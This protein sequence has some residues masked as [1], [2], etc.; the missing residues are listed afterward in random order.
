MTGVEFN[1][2]LDLVIDRP[3]SRYWSPPQRNDFIRMAITNAI[4]NRTLRND[5]IITEDAL[6][7]IY[8]SNATFTPTTNTLSLVAGGAGI[9]DYFH[10]MNLRAKYVIPV[11]VA[12]GVS[13]YIT[14]AS[15]STPLRIKL[16]VNTNLRTDSS[17]LISGVTTNTNANGTRYLKQISPK[18][19]ELYSDASLSTPIVGNG[20][21]TGTSGTIQMILNNYAKP[22]DSNHKFSKLGEATVDNPL[23]EISDTVVKI[24]PLTRVC[25]EATID[26]V[27]TPVYINVQD[28]VIDLNAT[29]GEDFLNFI[30]QETAVL[31]GMAS[32]DNEMTGN[33]ITVINQ[34]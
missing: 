11:S 15:N 16:N 10:L 13:V 32:R 9:S 4:N 22:L 12:L 29:Y 27:S 19:F 31:M 17:V 2:K 8:K 30:M 14:E 3:Y 33:A 34:A 1:E 28:A 7:G 6:F 21:Y 18:W 26:Y 24:Y 25:S 5:N 23:Y 20:V